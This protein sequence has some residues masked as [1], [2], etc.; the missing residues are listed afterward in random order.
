MARKALCQTTTPE[1]GVTVRIN[2]GVALSPGSDSR[3]VNWPESRLF[4]NF[5]LLGSVLWIRA[6]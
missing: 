3:T 5:G 4:V 2:S 6:N 1:I